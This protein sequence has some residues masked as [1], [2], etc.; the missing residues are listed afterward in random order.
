MQAMSLRPSFVTAV[1]LT[2]LLPITAASRAQPPASALLVL[3]KG[4]RS[5]A[6]VDPQR[7]T[8]IGRADAGEDPHE[9]VA[10]ED[11][12]FAYVSNYGAFTTPGHTLSVVDL[13]AHKAL[14]ALDLGALRAPHGV[15][16]A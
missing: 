5:L 11:G 9:V 6:F 15:A 16:L 8:V 3:E 10:S 14:P 12:R 1:C 7:L 13:A 4:A 2:L